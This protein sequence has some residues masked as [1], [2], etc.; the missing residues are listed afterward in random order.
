MF[1]RVMVA[2][3]M[4]V[5][6]WLSVL[7]NVVKVVI[8]MMTF[9]GLHDYGDDDVELGITSCLTFIFGEFWKFNN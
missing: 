9:G 5:V 4:V 1:A 3:N 8:M 6:G 7:K 2:M